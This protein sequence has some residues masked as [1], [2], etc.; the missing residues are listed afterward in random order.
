MPPRFG[1]NAALALLLAA[2]PAAAETTIP[3][4]PITVQVINDSDW[5]DKK[6]ML[7]L[8]G[9]A[10]VGTNPD[11]SKT[12]YPFSVS[13][14][15]SVDMG[16]TSPTV[17]TGTP[18]LCPTNP[19][20]PNCTPFQQATNAATGAP[21]TVNSP[22]S[23][24][25]NLPVYQF[26]MSS[27]SSGTLFVS[28]GTGVTVPPAP[29]VT[30]TYRF[31]PLE[32]SY[33]NAIVSNGDL[34]SID[35]YGIPFELRTFKPGDTTFTEPL[36][37]VTY[38]SSTPTLLAAFQAANP[39]LQNVFVASSTS[40]NTTFVPGTTPYTNFLR[41]IGP[42]QVAAP[43]VSPLPVAP[44]QGKAKPW[45]Y[46]SFAAHLDALADANYTFTESDA[47]QVS[48]YTFNYSGTITRMTSQ[49]TASCLNPSLAVDGWLI[50]LVG[51]TAAPSPLPANADICIPLPRTDQ[52]NGSADFIIYGAVQ[53][54]ESLGLASN[55][56]LYACSDSDAVTLGNITNSVYGWIQADVL[57]ALNFGYMNGAAD[58]ANGGVGSS[59]IWYGMPPMQYPF[60]RARVNNDGRYNLWAALMYNHS[61]AYGFAFSDRNGRPSPDIA[62]PIG[63]TLRLWILPDQR[64]DAP[65]AEVVAHDGGSITL[66][67][68]AVANA[69]HYVV[70][71][72]P[73][74]ETASATVAQPPAG[75]PV[76]YQITSLTAGTP[77]TIT[78]RAFNADE[79]QRSHDLPLY[80]RTS[81]TPPK[82]KAADA[83]V[84]FGFNWTPPAY[85]SAQWPDLYIAGVK[86]LYA[87]GG[88]YAQPPAFPIDVG[89]T[90]ATAP[91]T[92]TPAS[93]CQPPC[94][95][96][97]IVPASIAPG[98][99]ATLTITISNPTTS[100]SLALPNGFAVPM[101]AGVTASAVGPQCTGVAV[102]AGNIV[103]GAVTVN[104]SGPTCTITASLTSSSPGTV[105]VQAPALVTD[106]GTAPASSAPL[107]VTG[108]TGAVALAISPATIVAGGVATLTVT[109]ANPTA[110]AATLTAPFVDV[111]PPGVT[112]VSTAAGGSCVGTTIDAA[113][114]T[115]PAGASIPVGG[116]TIVVSIT[117]ST[118]GS[119]VNTTGL[120]ETSA[121]VYP[122]QSFPLEL[123]IGETTIW[124]ANYYLTFLGSSTLYSVG[125]CLPLESCAGSGL[126]P[127]V[128]F[129][130][131]RAPNYLERQGTNV[132]VTG[133]SNV[134]GPPFG[135]NAPTIGVSFTPIADKKF[136]P[137]VDA[138]PPAPP[139]AAA[140]VECPNGPASSGVLSCNLR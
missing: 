4:T 96:M 16:A 56:T 92:V 80:A 77:Y 30:A 57:A 40:G 119:V 84:N 24:K 46:P 74:Y 108:T 120:L 130:T 28:Y 26:T 118:P 136:A 49:T 7:L 62:F 132:T 3:Q 55:G 70:T 83:Q 99:S 121:T 8:A 29:T 37:R 100:Q 101:P 21:L 76:S 122:I 47:N 114:I 137:V 79:S 68:P 39:D 138:V 126:T 97:S 51:T 134:Y 63:G 53:N 35:F 52:G 82:P 78:V 41:V 20:L 131:G 59:G 18:L 133:G 139:G 44:P 25:T 50:T 127:V 124:S 112:I 23:G 19:P 10:V 87:G 104:A 34:T 109:L 9:K 66:Q 36:D 129:D 110:D 32:F 65:R 54:C 103:V 14:I 1:A 15:T 93:P 22:Y 45:P 116:C 64:L 75:A 6:V 5:S 61:D 102:N 33:S 60:G 91:L 107:S 123:K 67:W 43:G 125:P 115:L 105:V 48:A 113:E 135:A 88:S 17:T 58:K 27:V 31:Q 94:V 140:L 73:P 42:N 12:T 106:K 111:M 11:G 38:Y 89:L 81:G 117:S 85:L 13:G 128:P 69:D 71:W 2:V 90:P 98:G 86:S 95:T 72:T